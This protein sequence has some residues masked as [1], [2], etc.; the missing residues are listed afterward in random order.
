MEA[1]GG[2]NEWVRVTRANPCPIC[3]KPDWCLVHRTGDAA[4]CPRIEDGHDRDLGEAGYLHKLRGDRRVCL[5]A[6]LPHRKIERPRE[7]GLN[8][9]DTH[10]RYR[11]H[12]SL[13]WVAHVAEALGVEPA[14]L[15]RMEI[16]NNGSAAT[17]PMCNSRG[18][19]VGIRIRAMDG[20]KWAEKGSLNGVFIPQ[21]LGE[22]GL[23]FICEGPTDC[24]ALLGFGFDVIG[25]AS[26]NTCFAPSIQLAQGRDAVIVSDTDGPGKL[27]AD[28]LG[29]E[30]AMNRGIKSVRIWYPPAKKDVRDWICFAEPT[31]EIINAVVRQ[32]RLVA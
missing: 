26:C 11:D 29:K 7:T 15:L 10:R 2:M 3:G 16:G 5:P 22:D 19:I 14:C 18:E 8:W 6:S 20:R 23:F 4:I 30:M 32:A 31:R 9:K 12:A 28:K 13:E 25:R 21:G 1:H 27:Y 17:F 24:A